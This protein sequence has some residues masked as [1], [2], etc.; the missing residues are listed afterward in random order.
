MADSIIYI[1]THRSNVRGFH[2]R[3]L[4]N[5]WRVTVVRLKQLIIKINEQKPGNSHRHFLLL[6]TK[7]A[8]FAKP[9]PYSTFPNVFFFTSFYLNSNNVLRF[10]DL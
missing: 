10:N 4:K 6:I 3:A 7:L 2:S 8:P 1:I 5:H 9:F